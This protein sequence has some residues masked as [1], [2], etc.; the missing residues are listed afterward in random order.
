MNGGHPTFT[1]QIEGKSPL[2][3]LL[4]GKAIKLFSSTSPKT[5]RL[6]SAPVQTGRAFGISYKSA[7][8][9]MNKTKVL[10]EKSGLKTRNIGQT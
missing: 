8:C 10:R 5:L 2:Y 6:D 4:L 7:W 9:N 3:H 1:D